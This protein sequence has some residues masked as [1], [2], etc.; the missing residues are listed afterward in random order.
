M[1]C[2]T[3]NTIIYTVHYTPIFRSTVSLVIHEAGLS[4]LERPAHGVE[5][6]MAP[7]GGGKR[8]RGD[9]TFS[10]DSR[11]EGQRPSPHRP[12]DLNLGRQSAQQ[13]PQYNQDQRRGSIDHSGGG[14]RRG[15]RGGR[16]RGSQRSPMNS[17]HNTQFQTR[18]NP[19][20]SN[21]SSPPIPS[22]KSAPEPR[23]EPSAGPTLPRE[24]TATQTP[25]PPPPEPIPYYYEFLTDLRI[26]SWS[27]HGRSEIVKL[28]VAAREAEDALQLGLLFQELVFSGLHGSLDPNDAGTTIRDILGIEST[29]QASPNEAKHNYAFDASSLFLDTIS[30]TADIPKPSPSLLP[31]V[32]AT[33][34]PA[35]KLRYELDSSL[36]ESLGLVRSNVFVKVG[37]R[38]QTNLLYRQSNYNL[39]REESEGYSKLV[40][41]LFTTSNDELPTSEVVE[42]TFERVKGMIGAFDLDVGRVLDISLDVFA[43][44]LVKQYRFFV[45]YFRASSWWPQDDQRSVPSFR[46]Q[47]GPL[48]RW[49]L[50]GSV[51]RSLN[52]E[53]KNEILEARCDRDGT[54]WRRAREIGMAAFFELGGRQTE[55]S[56][57][58]AAVAA[59][60]ETPTSQSEEDRQWIKLTKTLPP[61]GSKVAAQ[62]LGFK[63]RFYTSSARDS[64]DVLPVN[65]IYLAALLIKIG[66]ISL[67]DLYPHLWPAE[68]GMLKLKE[69]KLQEKAEKEKLNRPGGGVPNALLSAAPL[70]DDTVDPR[71]A[72]RLRDS[73]AARR[74]KKV[75]TAADVSTPNAQVDERGEEL[76]EPVEQK[77]QLL[78]SLLAIG[79]LPE[80]LYILGRFPWLVEAFPEMPDYIHRLL[81]YSLSKVYESLRPLQD[82]P[83]LQEPQKPTDEGA[84]RGLQ[85]LNVMDAP[86]RKRKRWAQLDQD[87]VNEK[88][89]VVD[90]RFYWDEWADTIPV[91]QTVDD[92]F[93]LCSTLLNLSGVKIGQDPTLLMK[94]ARI[95]SHS[96]ATDTSPS[97]VD[98]WVGLSKRLLVPALSFAKSNPGV[99][100]E[101]FELL[102]N[103]AHPIRYSIYAEWNSGQISRQPDMKS[104]F[105]Q[106]KAE[107]RD[108]LKRISKTTLK[109]M[110]R[111]LA[112]VAYANPGIVF[113]VA[114]AQLESYENIID[115]VVECARYFTYLAYDVLTWSL[116]SALGGQGRNRVQADGMLTSKWLAALSLFAGKVFKR[117]SVMTPTPIVQYVAEQ[118]RQ[119]NST[120]LIV[121][122][123]IV[124]SMAGIVSDSSF[125][126]AQVLAMAGGD[127]LQAQTMLQ[128]LD[129]RHESKNTAKRLMKSLTDSKLAGQVLVSI[130][131]ER[132][133]CIFKI[134]EEEAHPKL[135][136]NLFDQLHRIFIQ[137]YELLRSNL[138]IKDFD[139]F[140]PSVVQL[141]SDFGI[142]TSIAFWISRPSIIAAM[143]EYDVKYGKRNSI[144]KISPS[145]DP[146][147]SE[148][149]TLGS[150]IDAEE[151]NNT[152]KD[153][154]VLPEVSDDEQKEDGNDVKM[155]DSVDDVNA[156]SQ[157]PTAEADA[158][159]EP[160]HPVLKE[161]IDGLYPALPSETWKLMSLPFYV[162]F[163]QCSLRDMLLPLQ[164]Y[165]DEINRQR[166]K[167]PALKADRSDLSIVGTQRKDRDIKALEDLADRLQKESKERLQNYTQNRQRLQREK[168]H[169]FADF[170]GKF[171][172]LNLALIEHCFFPRI[173]L[174]AVD[175][176]Y[177]FKMLK[178]L[179]SS[180]ATNFRTMGV[181]DQLFKTQRLTSMIFLT[182]S[183]EAENFGRFLNQILGDLSAWHKD[184]AKFEKEAYG[185][186]RDLPGFAKRMN[187][188]KKTIAAFWEYEDF[189][190]ILRK[191]HMNLTNALKAC[192]LGGEYMHIRNAINILNNIYQHFP[193][194][195]FMGN[196]IVDCVTRLSQKESR[197]DL[198]LAAASLLG[199]LKR[200]EKHWVMPQAFNLGEGG[201]NAPNGIR[202]RSSKPSTPKPENDGSVA[203]NPKAPDFQP[204]TNGNTKSTKGPMGSIDAEDGEIDD[205]QMADTSNKDAHQQPEKIAKELLSIGAD[206][207]KTRVASPKPA[208]GGDRGAPRPQAP[209]S[210]PQAQA[211]PP[212]KPPMNHVASN[213]SI[214]PRPESSR[215][216]STNGRGPQDL[217]PRPEIPHTRMGD[218][219][220]PPRPSD[221]ASQDYQ[222]DD[223]FHERQPTEIPRDLMR[224]RPERLNPRHGAERVDGRSWGDRTDRF[225]GENAQPPRPGMDDRN[226]PQAHKDSRHIPR[227]ERTAIPP[228][229]RQS[230]EYSQGQE[231][232]ENP[233]LPPRSTISQQP[234]R[235]SINPERAALI[236]GRQ[237]QTRGPS[238]PLDRR[239]DA[240]RQGE[241]PRSERSSR[242]PSPIRHVDRGHPFDGQRVDRKAEDGH[243]P[244]DDPAYSRAR[245]EDG[246][247]PSGPRTERSGPGGFSNPSSD[248]FR[249]S[250]KPTAPTGPAAFDPNHGRLSQ[251]QGRGSRQP[252]SQFGRLNA[253]NDVPSGP[254]L[255]NGN[256][257]PSNRGGRTVSAPQ[258][259]SAPHHSPSSS[260]SNLGA[261]PAQDRQT[262]SGPSMR[263]PPRDGPTNV[264]S[265]AAAPGPLTP[266]S[267]ASDATGVHPDR[268]KAIQGSGIPGQTGV[269]P[270]R[271]RAIEGNGPPGRVGGPGRGEPSRGPRQPPPL[272]VPPAQNPSRLSGPMPSPIQQSPPGY[273]G[274]A[275]PTGPSSGGDRGRD[276]RFAGLQ[277][278]LQQNG[279]PPSERSNQGTSIRGR[280]GRTMPP[281][282]SA[283]GPPMSNIPAR[284]D[285]G[286]S[287][288]DLFAGRANGPAGPSNVDEESSYGRGARRGPPRETREGERRSGRHRSR[289]PTKD[290]ASNVP[291]RLRDEERPPPPREDPRDRFR[292]DMAPPVGVRS[293]AGPN[294]R[295]LR[296]PPPTLPPPEREPRGGRPI[297]GTGREETV[298]RRGSRDATYDGRGGE[299]RRDGGGSMRKRG[300]GGEE[301]GVER[302]MDGKRPRRS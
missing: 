57:M 160:W 94:L 20:S 85:H 106:A 163:W 192:L 229:S 147:E 171:D 156:V 204:T 167:I 216:T 63:L 49:A 275:P 244:L 78:K 283:P 44:V 22:P 26:E 24:S 262:P 12:G 21:Q 241:M 93:T 42:E 100:N 280:G 61:T 290:R 152:S 190:R 274:P 301:A 234:E 145:K 72:T 87:N 33:G 136:G 9:R 146:T 168:E 233:M 6:E 113:S 254:R 137:Y 74:A 92:V 298:D 16:G 77:V 75:D 174:S 60:D 143:A 114:I 131:Q 208:D 46:Q 110:A 54:F 109:P 230:L 27:E 108:V 224:D 55:E 84:A 28:G 183:K 258:P 169:W 17:P 47:L 82:Q 8:K 191:W 67:K 284:E 176:M 29:V 227:D 43:T 56:V 217:P 236:H 291:P 69:E 18:P 62:V 122:E 76:S 295:D 19:G 58:N 272:S 149:K 128:L 13:Q 115:V 239:P 273:G 88:D 164:S 220:I 264:P 81:H 170:W 48:P 31:L 126:E 185:L 135:L 91:C 66:F 151:A 218:H 157:P 251:D 203:L 199:N 89:E 246:Y 104:Q 226:G 125:N 37:I 65:I 40:T 86:S 238:H 214:P 98:R 112:K 187:P 293:G 276:K 150:T 296:G 71:E 271:L 237:D 257:P 64:S 2:A 200:M 270:D 197:G 30:I 15:G 96:L 99:V 198:K 3:A 178:Y 39:L 80:A 245:Y 181:Y 52:E 289:S 23:P 189:R 194:V 265:G 32:I 223:R 105:E 188:D 10:Q 255:P 195:T 97:N 177:T 1:V 259:S 247:A 38:Q 292:N 130:A 248:R 41:D 129:K 161:I 144:S 228:T 302:H 90:Y 297:R 162:T 219:R 180:G 210:V 36:L 186:K 277:G 172:D 252:E 53:E 159:V 294:D 59:I 175:A 11:D 102:K 101:V 207:A 155:Q 242:G 243:R 166:K 282:P 240:S 111:A 253:G 222:R 249:E 256:H 286:P 221:R 202:A 261:A 287:R 285:V 213:P 119:A 4:K 193:A 267:E 35:Q 133:T 7:G 235:A 107:T 95:G 184:K 120:D 205:I 201:P 269:H 70:P 225:G 50:P 232:R 165:E 288:D 215:N 123:E 83:T 79:A 45:K 121:L 138:S 231:E 68:D 103:F 279:P 182:T 25:N 153:Q 142:D 73:E 148:S 14:G 132:Q 124:K 154:E 281:S 34:I 209:S 179:H 116:M 141:I 51:G 263:G 134:E 127:L 278:V 158:V 117:Y 268:L 118:L 260:Q 250:M 173:T 211:G 5:S 266:T 139:R 212:R 196:H 299:E 140:V 206:V 300:R